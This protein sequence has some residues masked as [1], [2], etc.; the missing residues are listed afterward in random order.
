MI[1]ELEKIIKFNGIV[2]AFV[3]NNKEWKRWYMSSQ[4]EIDQLP[5]EWEEKCN[6]LEKMIL[7]KAVRPDRVL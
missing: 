3:H 2:G 7:L 5:G 4:P 6:K 1:C